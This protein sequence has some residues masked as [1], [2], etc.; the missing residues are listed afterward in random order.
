M[1]M[2]RPS[3]FGWF[4]MTATSFRSS[5]LENAQTLFGMRHLTTAEHDRDLDLRPCLEEAQHVLLLRGV[6]ADVDLRAELHFLGFDLALVLARL[7]GLDCLVV[8]ELSIVHDAAHGRFSLRSDLDQVVAFVISDALSLL[9]RV[10]SHLS[11]VIGDK[12]TFL[13]T[14]LVVEP[15]FLGSYRAHLLFLNFFLV[16][17]SPSSK[18]KARTQ[19]A[20]RMLV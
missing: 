4:S 13:G 18:T 8:L 7:L 19:Q 1:C 3:I 2:L 5:A 10:D 6:V 14:D 16:R 12:T 11:S 15:W 9:D 17:K 20:I